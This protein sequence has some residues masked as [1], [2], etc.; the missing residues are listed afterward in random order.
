VERLAGAIGQRNLWQYPGLAAAAEYVEAELRRTGPEVAS[1]RFAVDGHEVRNLELV[2]PGGDRPEEIVLVG[3]HY[4]SVLGSPG[5]NDNATGT[6]AVLELA[7]LLAGRRLSRTVRLVAFVNEEPPFFRTDDMGSLRYARR[8][9]ER[10]ERICAMLC[11]ETI[12][13]YSTLPGSQAYPLPFGLFH[14]ATADFVAFVAN[15]GS[16]RLGRRA[17][18]S[19]RR[20]SDFPCEASVAPGWLPGVGWSDHWAFWQQGYPAIM[21]TDTALFRYAPYHMP[22]DTPEKIDYEG[23]AR[24]VAGLARVVEELAG[25]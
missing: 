12:G 22:H 8:C 23:T 4:D 2:L 15:L 7:R 20:H 11:L 16:G 13:Y 14:P 3:A 6:A 19:F 5:A 1:Q 9:A 25:S 18:A 10:G 24:V 21:V 17:A